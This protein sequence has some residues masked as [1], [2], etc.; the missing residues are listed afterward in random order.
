MARSDESA[1]IALTLEYAE[2]VRVRD[3]PRWAATWTE[4]ARWVLGADRDVVGIDAI[5]D[6]WSTSI[7]KYSVVAQVYTACTYDIDG[8]TATGRCQ[9]L[10]L[11]VRQDGGRHLLAG[12]YDDS[13]RRTDEG[14][15]FTSR[16][17]TKY[18][19]GPPTL[20]GQF[21]TT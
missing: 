19:A 15:R 3:V 9:L 6:M 10:E 20:M 21:F 13:Y 1:L 16:R 11:N 7:A 18:Y 14:W 5:V 17:I 4:D 8:D 12:H 2:A